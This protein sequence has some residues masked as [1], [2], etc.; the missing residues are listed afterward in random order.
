MEKTYDPKTGSWRL[1]TAEPYIL[2]EIGSDSYEPL[3]KATVCNPER[4]EELAEADIPHTY[5]QSEYNAKVSQLIRERYDMDAEFAILRQR[6]T[7][8]EEFAAYNAFAEACKA[9]AKRV[10]TEKAQTENRTSSSP[11][12][13]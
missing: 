12:P 13:S 7:K 3:H 4:W 11:R 5:S 6:D 2:H 1:V 9:E 10:L 8:P